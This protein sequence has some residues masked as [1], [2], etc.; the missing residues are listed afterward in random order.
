[1]GGV[2]LAEATVFGKRELF[3]HFLL[4]ALGI[5]RD[6]AASATLELGHVVFNLAHTFTNLNKFKAFPLYGKKPFPSILSR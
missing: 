1:V 4:V 3:F 5:M 6:A 2:F